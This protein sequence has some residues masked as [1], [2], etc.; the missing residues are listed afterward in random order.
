MG[1][2]SGVA[3]E[4][5]AAGLYGG[6]VSLDKVAR[7]FSIKAD[8]VSTVSYRALFRGNTASGQANARGGAVGVEF[9]A[10]LLL[11]DSD[12]TENRAGYGPAVW[13][14]SIRDFDAAFQP[15]WINPLYT[16]PQ[17]GGS[18]FWIET[19]DV[20][21]NVAE[22]ADP[23][24]GAVSLEGGA[25]VEIIGS[26][27]E[28]NTATI[29]AAVSAADNTT[30]V[31]KSSS[32]T[33]NVATATGAGL[34]LADRATATVKSST[35]KANIATSGAAI[36]AVGQSVLSLQ[37]SSKNA[38]TPDQKPGHLTSGLCSNICGFGNDPP[39]TTEFC[40][41]P[42]AIPFDSSHFKFR[43]RWGAPVWNI[44]ISQSLVA[45]RHLIH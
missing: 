10:G 22:Q 37:V 11:Q 4:S 28:A 34:R 40:L 19:C 32:F 23:G 16:V 25:Q 26:N 44:A 21:S 45:A 15:I 18:R 36:A 3:A 5:N 7:T 27:F 14:S 17:L 41:V 31:I 12:F 9:S 42:G 38:G 13:F 30:V 35:F 43:C 24:T 2:L 29:G 39:D 6:A 20:S 33:G 8:S 1:R